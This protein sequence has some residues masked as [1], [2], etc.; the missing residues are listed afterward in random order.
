MTVSHEQ[1]KNVLKKLKRGRATTIEGALQHMKFTDN[2][3]TIVFFFAL[4]LAALFSETPKI[5]SQGAGA[6]STAS[7]VNG[8][9]RELKSKADAIAKQKQQQADFSRNRFAQ[10]H[11]YNPKY[12]E[13]EYDYA[14]R[15]EI[16]ADE[17]KRNV[18]SFK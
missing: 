10:Q 7:S 16:A 3:S 18:D 12:S 15:D 2:L 6:S 9:K 11:A 1:R 8:L 14:K 4:P 17:A 13:T 5:K